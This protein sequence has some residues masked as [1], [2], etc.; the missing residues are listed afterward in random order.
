MGPIWYPHPL[1]AGYG[2]SQRFCL[3]FSYS[4]SMQRYCCLHNGIQYTHTM[5]MYTILDWPVYACIDS[6]SCQIGDRIVWYYHHQGRGQRKKSV[7]F[8]ALPESPKPPP[9]T[10]SGNLVL[11]FGRQKDVLRV[12][13]EKK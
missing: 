9:D 8:Q 3:F 2:N 12:R 4:A 13:P 10:N 5:H 11:F 1:T 7:F 6:L